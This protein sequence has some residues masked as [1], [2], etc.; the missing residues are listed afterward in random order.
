MP[1]SKRRT[2]E[3][4]KKQ[5][6]KKTMVPF[7]GKY[8]NQVGCPCHEAVDPQRKKIQQTPKGSMLGIP[9][10]NIYEKGFSLRLTG[11]MFG[12]DLMNLMTIVIRCNHF[13]PIRSSF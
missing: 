12:N 10:P 5:V 13:N 9:Y 7:L 1:V 3:K 11:V 2:P 4:K 8:P 6:L